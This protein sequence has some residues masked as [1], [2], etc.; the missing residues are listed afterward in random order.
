VPLQLRDLRLLDPQLATSYPSAILAR[1]RALVV[2]LEYIK[3]IITQDC[4]LVLNPGGHVCMVCS[5][6]SRQPE[7]HCMPGRVIPRRLLPQ[8]A[9][10]RCRQ[11]CCRLTMHLVPILHSTC[12]LCSYRPRSGLRA[13]STVT[14][15]LASSPAEVS[16]IHSNV[17]RRGRPGDG[18]R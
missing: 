7:R 1:E 5:T 8:L 12:G 3:C 6:A 13:L 9:T 15:A 10:L 14:E 16:E 18:L 11:P 4:V 17:L 2:N